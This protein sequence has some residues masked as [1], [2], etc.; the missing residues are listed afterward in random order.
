VTSSWRRM[1]DRARGGECDGGESSSRESALAV[2]RELK[3]FGRKRIDMEGKIFIL[4]K[5]IDSS[6]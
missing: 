6:S 3:H 5:H 2:C 1:T 4:L